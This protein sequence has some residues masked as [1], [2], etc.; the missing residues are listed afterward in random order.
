MP[1]IP[2]SGQRLRVLS[3]QNCRIKRHSFLPDRENDR[4]DFSGDGETRELR[5]HPSCDESLVAVVQRP[6]QADRRSSRF[7]ED[8]LERAIEV[9]VK[10]SIDCFASAHGSAAVETVIGARTRRDCQTGVGP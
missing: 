1:S 8:L 7:L 4:S 3:V 10:T 6:R 9:A 5:P 2:R